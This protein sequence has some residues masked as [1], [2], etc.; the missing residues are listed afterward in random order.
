MKLVPVLGT[1]VLLGVVV[2]LVLG[3]QLAADVVAV[4][5]IHILFGVVGVILVI[6]LAIVA[7]RSKVA[8]IYSKVTISV[9]S[10]IALIQVGLG[11]QLLGG[12]ESLVVLHEVNGFLMFMFS[13]LVGGITF[14]SARRNATNALT[15]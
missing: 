13:L 8:T 14:W 10:I 12:S 1:L 9:L 6:G 7:K 4:R 3:F 2:Q 11:F 15:P 5:G